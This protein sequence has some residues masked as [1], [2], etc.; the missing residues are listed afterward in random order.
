[1]ISRTRIHFTIANLFFRSVIYSTVQGR[2]FKERPALTLQVKFQ[3]A[4]FVY[5]RMTIYINCIWLLCTRV[6][7]VKIVSVI[8]YH[9]IPTQKSSFGCV[10]ATDKF[11]RL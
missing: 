6:F 2:L 3:P 7:K 9:L 11:D 10:K 8:Q 1:M 5:V 4:V